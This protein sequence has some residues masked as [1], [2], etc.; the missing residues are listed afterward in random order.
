VFFL[1]VVEG[2]QN[3]CGRQRHG[4]LRLR[5]RILLSMTHTL[6]LYQ[7]RSYSDF[8]KGS[9]YREYSRSGTTSNSIKAPVTES[10]AKL[11][12]QFL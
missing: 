3:I 6:R 5:R 1:D 11:R 10:V 9:V 7:F 12:L 8:Q 4:W 2:A